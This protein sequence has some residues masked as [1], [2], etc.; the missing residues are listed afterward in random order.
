MVTAVGKK[1]E[2]ITEFAP[3]YSFFEINGAGILIDTNAINIFP[4]NDAIGTLVHAAD[5]SNIDTVM[6]NGK[7]LKSGGK[8]IGTDLDSLKQR[9]EPSVPYLLEKQSTK[10]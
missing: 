7:I 5:R 6:V 9:A 3:A 10:I 4:S 8:L 2:R 1:L